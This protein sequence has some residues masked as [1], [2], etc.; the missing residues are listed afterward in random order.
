MTATT[1]RELR[2]RIA[3][4]ENAIDVI[5]VRL[6]DTSVVPKRRIDQALGIVFMY[7]SKRPAAPE[8]GS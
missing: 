5:G 4:L 8:S 2:T 6:S 3:D 7:A 1:E